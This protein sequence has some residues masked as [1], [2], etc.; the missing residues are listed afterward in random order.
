M[1]TPSAPDATALSK[2]FGRS[3]G[4]NRS[5]RGCSRTSSGALRVRCIGSVPPQTVWVT[6][7]GLPFAGR[8]KNSS[9][10][11]RARA[12]AGTTSPIVT[13]VPLATLPMR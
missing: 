6:S 4:T 8:T 2:R 13:F 5:V 11:A 1:I 9:T 12:T 10:T 7:A 3:P